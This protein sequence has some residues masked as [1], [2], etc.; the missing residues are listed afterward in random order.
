VLLLDANKK[1]VEQ[2]KQLAMSALA[3]D[4]LKQENTTL[5]AD[6]DL[7]PQLKERCSQLAQDNHNLQKE[8]V[9]LLYGVSSLG[10][11]IKK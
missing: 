7:L 11:N 6:A 1:L 3:M 4:E 9:S 5:R 10:I 2:T 8:L